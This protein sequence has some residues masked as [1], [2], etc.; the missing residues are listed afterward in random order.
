MCTP[1]QNS[2]RQTRSAGSPPDVP[3]ASAVENNPFVAEVLTAQTRP[4]GHMSRRISV[5]VA[6]TAFAVSSFAQAADRTNDQECT[7]QEKAQTEA[8]QQEPAQD[9]QTAA[10]A[11][12]TLAEL[13]AMVGA[14]A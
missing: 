5:L 11:P 8:R 13:F 2:S 4:G 3:S 14:E 12:V 7:R 6:A 10:P 1:P 9:V